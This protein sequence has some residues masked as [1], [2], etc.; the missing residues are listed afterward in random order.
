MRVDQPVRDR[1]IAWTDAA[2]SGMTAVFLWS[3]KT[4]WLYTQWRVPKRVIRRLLPRRDEQIGFLELAGVALALTTFEHHLRDSAWT[5]WCDNQGVVGAL[6][7]G[8]TGAQDLN[9]IVGQFWILVAQ[10]CIDLELGRV[11]SAANIAD[12]PTRGV[13]TWI[14]RVQA[15][16]VAPVLPGWLCDPWLAPDFP[17]FDVVQ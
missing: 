5:C 14:D 1:C 3:E 16:F 10:S 17:H 8:G 11:A 12:E 4:G 6:L 2:G 9:A 7:K 13:R 15:E